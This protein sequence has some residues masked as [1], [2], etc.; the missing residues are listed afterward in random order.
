MSNG[1]EKPQRK[2]H[3]ILL[4]AGASCTSGYPLADRLRLLMSSEKDFKAELSR[5]LPDKAAFTSALAFDLLFR[6]NEQAIELFRHGGFATIDEFSK[7]AGA[8]YPKEVQELKKLLRFVLAIDNPEENFTRSDY[9]V[10]IQ[11]LF[12]SDLFSLR[13]DVTTLTFNDD[14]YLPYL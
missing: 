14:P 11:K 7:L 13:D 5:V 1:T 4:G 2:K 9:Y 8:K 10:F 3:V 12:R 6:P